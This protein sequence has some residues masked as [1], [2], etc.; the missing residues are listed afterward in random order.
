MVV[1]AVTD[2]TVHYR[3]RLICCGQNKGLFKLS[4]LIFETFHLCHLFS[5]FSKTIGMVLTY[6]NILIWEVRVRNLSYIS[7]IQMTYINMVLIT[8]TRVFKRVYASF[9]EKV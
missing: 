2:E 7:G 4:I 9:G 3:K 5:N 8:S 1:I 6:F